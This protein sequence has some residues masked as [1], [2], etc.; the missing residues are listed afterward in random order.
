M[1]KEIL[2]VVVPMVIG[3]LISLGMVFSLLIG[4]HIDS[5][6][7]GA[8]LF[9]GFFFWML[10]YTIEYLLSDY[11]YK[12][13]MIKLQYL[14]I[15]IVPL[16]YFLLVLHIS[17]Y[18]NWA[19]ARRNFFL[20]IIPVAT[21]ALVFTNEWHGLIYAEISK[22][23]PGQYSFIGVV[24]GPFFWVF[25]GYIY[26]LFIIGLGILIRIIV[27]RI[28]LFKMQSI[29]ILI[30]LTISWL[31]SVVDIMQLYTI[32]F[33][34]LALLASSFI[35]IYS[36]RF[37]KTGDI[38]PVRF[39]SGIRSEKDVVLVI[40]NRERLIK[41]NPT[42]EEL[43]DISLKDAVGKSIRCI[44]GDFNRFSS[45]K[46]NGKERYATFKKGSNELT[47]NVHVNFLAGNSESTSYKVF[48]LNDITERVEAEKAIKESEKKFRKIF[49]NSRDGIY[50]STMD[51]KY[52]D[53]NN[54]MVEMLGYDSRQ[55]LMSMDIGK[56]IYYSRNDRPKPDEREKSFVTRLKKKDGTPIWVEINANVVRD[57]GKE[58]H[59]EGVVRDI[60]ERV[61]AQQQIKY[62]SCHDYLTD[63]FNRY[64]FEQELK[65]LDSARLYP[66]CVIILDINGLKL[67]ND[68]FGRKKGDEIL[69]KTAKI[70]KKCF[71]KE[72]IV[73]RYGGDEF[74][75]LLTSTSKSVASRAVNRVNR[76]FK[77]TFKK[78]FVSSLS[79]G[80][81]VKKS[82]DEDINDLVNDAEDSMYRHKLVEKQSSHSSLI[83]SL[84]RALAERN[85]ETHAH[86]ERMKEYALQLGKEINLSDD[87]LSELGLLSALHDIGK[88]S[89]TDNI[90]LKPAKLTAS[91]FEQMKKH[92]EIGHKIA[93]ANPDLATIADGILYHHER[94]DGKGYPM[95]LKGEE[96]PLMARIITIVDSYDA[97]TSNR[98]YRKSQGK[99]YAIKELKENAGTQFDPV[100]VEHFIKII[101]KNGSPSKEKPLSKS[102]D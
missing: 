100:L 67:V 70:I 76:E 31:A 52:L 22:I 56:D 75:I 44:W 71:R 18:T 11:F 91:E 98:V 4:R 23:N 49:E 89:I 20:Y 37:L 57:D 8:L 6:K 50:Q 92:S 51:G 82:D 34:P 55:E 58:S 45:F 39:E 5:Y 90:V 85:Y 60:D 54:A 99:R 61:R 72:D 83:T 28:K 59:Y 19:K 87:K 66:I 12:V 53:V 41:I 29:S 35:L 94:W 7:I 38:M 48:T 32:S 93:S 97:M 36:F 26:L 16:T 40:D 3:I 96:I 69:K 64:F 2:L 81:A 88:I 77:S 9:S 42:G 24:Y 46:G 80:I 65:R 17:G 43:F 63:L 15:A 30:V 27:S 73:A 101:T 33:T 74:I 79:F 25:V 78:E 21:I 14:G 84:Q 1:N 62:L 95:G 13:L 47:Y 86:M 10:F 102:H 68:T